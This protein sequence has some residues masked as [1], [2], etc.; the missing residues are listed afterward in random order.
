MPDPKPEPESR[1]PLGEPLDW[2]QDATLDALSEISESDIQ[3]AMIWAETNADPE[4]RGLWMAT[5][6]EQ[7]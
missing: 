5:P 7:E 4:D 3:S 6:E 1:V 2:S